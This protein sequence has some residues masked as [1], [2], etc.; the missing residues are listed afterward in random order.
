M[1]Q[2]KQLFIVIRIRKLRKDGDLMDIEKIKN[3]SC[4]YISSLEYDSFYYEK[5]EKQRRL[6]K[7]NK[8]DRFSQCLSAVNKG[9]R[10]DYLNWLHKGDLITDQ[11]CADAVYSIWTMQERFYR[12]GMSKEKLVKMIKLAEKSP[13]LQSDIDDLSYQ[14]IITIYRGVKVNNYRGLSW[15]VDKSVA[16]WFARRFGHD[17][18]SVMYLLEQLIK[19]I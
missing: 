6:E 1:E 19:R 2:K 18:I 5:D 8:A 3:A 7:I 9:N 15:T 11:E 17:G 4:I 16:E 10:F 13:L 12:C 14:N